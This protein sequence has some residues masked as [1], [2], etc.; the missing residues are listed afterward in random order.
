MPLSA[1]RVLEIAAGAVVV[2]GA[3]S[4][5]AWTIF[6][7]RPT[8]T[9][10]E[11]ARRHLLSQSGRLVDGTLLDVCDVPA[12]DG[13]NLKMLLYGYRIGG[14]DYECTQDVTELQDVIDIAA[15]RAGFPCSVRYQPGNPQ[16][17]I[18]VSE[19]WSGVRD[20]LPLIPSYDRHFLG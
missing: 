18:V 7:K 6:R 14:V 13:R 3:A 8:A 19:K 17:S 1:V 15:I 11:V 4:F 9:E 10:L 2:A 16:N 20:S 12:E 5:G